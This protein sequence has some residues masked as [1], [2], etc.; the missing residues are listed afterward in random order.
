MMKP[1]CFRPFAPLAVACSLV[2]ASLAIAPPLYAEPSD[3]DMAQARELLN[4]GLRLREK[5]DPGA[6]LEKL[7]GAHALA[8]TPITGLELG[9]DYVALGKL[10]EAREIFLSVARIAPRADETSRSAAA[11]AECESQAKEL[12]GRIPTLSVKVSGVPVDTVSV[13]IDGATVPTEALPAPRLLNP[14]P[15]S[16]AARSTSG[17]TAE[18]T[19]DLKEGEPREVELKI[20]L[21]GTP[22]PAGP[23]GLLEAS[24]ATAASPSSR[25]LGW[26]LLGAG[27]AVGIGG[28]VIMGVAAGQ[29]RDAADRLD[30]GDSDAAK[31][32][33][34]VGVVGA[35]AGGI[36][37]LSGVGV[38]LVSPH[39]S[40][41]GAQGPA[42]W[43]GA[44]PCGVEMGGAW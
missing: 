39:A 11:R 18:T 20:I 24:S 22:T 41:R 8:H 31:T 9:R 16:V 15:H 33:W 44:N 2:L 30:R 25:V 1:T 19:V 17:G 43:I 40:G 37:A 32:L 26:A 38:L 10:V 3:S 6:A 29:S 13:A 7:R 42:L 12:R 36:A 5:G 4:E 34:T 35:I 23:T 27:A 28:G 21:V 14:G